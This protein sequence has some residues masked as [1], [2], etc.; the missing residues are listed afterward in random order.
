MKCKHCGQEIKKQTN[1]DRLK[2][3]QRVEDFDDFI[4]EICKNRGNKCPFRNGCLAIKGVDDAEC[5]FNTLEKWL[6]EE[7]RNE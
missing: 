2:T 5:F 6:F 7:T 4:E 1:F 3:F